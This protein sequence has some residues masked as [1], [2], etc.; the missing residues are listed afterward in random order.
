MKVF[1]LAC[2][3]QHHFEGWFGSGADYESQRDRGLI[4]CPVCESRSIQKMP[5]APRLNLSGAAA[6]SAAP[7]AQA[8]AERTGVD[9]AQVQAL[10]LQW[11][12]SVIQN[13]EDVGARFAEEAR[14]I[15]YQESP[16]RAIRGTASPEEARAL[17]EEGIEVLAIPLPTALK[18]PLQ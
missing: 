13:T 15:H 8:L 6:P 3:H 9:P 7:A 1:N 2:E 17:S 10:F 14:R 12:R 16:E 5:A 18:Q 4:E 11:A